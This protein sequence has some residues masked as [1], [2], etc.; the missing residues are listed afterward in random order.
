MSITILGIRYKSLGDIKSAV[1]CCQKAIEVEKATSEPD[2]ERIIM[3]E[4]RLHD[5]KT[6]LKKKNKK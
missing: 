3:Y 4:I 1:S 2:S 5:A 6:E